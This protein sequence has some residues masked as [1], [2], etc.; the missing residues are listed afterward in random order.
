[1]KKTGYTIMVA[2]LSGAAGALCI[3]HLKLSQMI[4]QRNE[5]VYADFA[6]NS[7]AG[8]RK[9]SAFETYSST[10]VDRSNT[11]YSEDFVMASEKSTQS[12]AFIKTVNEIEYQTGSW[13]DWFFQLRASQAIS[14][15]SGVIFTEDGYIVLIITL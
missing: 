11:G 8:T 12:V 4:D 7:Y 2:F 9:N 6:F 10:T 3:N 15:G 5:V 1:M 14:S 13:M